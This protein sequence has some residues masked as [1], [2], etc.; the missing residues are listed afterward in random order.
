M[1]GYRFKYWRRGSFFILMPILII[2]AIQIM[3][4]TSDLFRQAG[5][6]EEVHMFVFI[7]S[8]VVP[9]ALLMIITANGKGHGIFHQ[10]HVEI[11]LGKKTHEIKYR[12]I[13]SVSEHISPP[14]NFYWVIS[15]P[16]ERSVLISTSCLPEG[17]NSLRQFMTDL[18][19]RARV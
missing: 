19:E 15:I 12:Q 7:A 13:E 10:K 5:I 1:K 17:K 8:L 6:S 14:G 2:S 18:K 16:G 4:H 9:F 11:R 3:D